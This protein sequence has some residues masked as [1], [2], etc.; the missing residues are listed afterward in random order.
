VGP[1]LAT[2]LSF[3]F[4][5]VKNLIPEAENV[6]SGRSYKNLQFP[7]HQPSFSDH[8]QQQHITYMTNKLPVKTSPR[9]ENKRT[10]KNTSTQ[11]KTRF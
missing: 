8:Y 5:G 7:F 1:Q 11:Y 4:C 10:Y 9:I 2:D 3:T 6:T